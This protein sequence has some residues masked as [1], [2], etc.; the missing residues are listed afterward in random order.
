MRLRVDEFYALDIVHSSCD[1][2]LAVGGRAGTADLA[3]GTT[4]WSS[5]RVDRARVNFGWDW[6]YDRGSQRIES[7][8]STLRS[9]A[10]LL[11]GAGMEL[12]EQGLRVCL[13][14]HMTR[15]RWER[16]VADHLGLPLAPV[17]P[18]PQT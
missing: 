17:V 5:R 10:L 14:L 12:G 11:D 16:V 3:L 7:Q 8:W 9:N 18:R 6:V 1:I 4:E 2:E 13:A 15:L